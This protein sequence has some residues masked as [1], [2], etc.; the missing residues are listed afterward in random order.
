MNADDQNDNDETTTVKPLSVNYTLAINTT[1]LA[2]I[3][4]QTLFIIT[5]TND[6][7]KLR[8]ENFLSLFILFISFYII[9]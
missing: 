7:Y 3:S 9:F 6:S 2:N 1:S 5:S 4:N 8:F